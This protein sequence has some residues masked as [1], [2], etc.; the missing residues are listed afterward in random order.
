MGN[1]DKRTVLGGGAYMVSSNST[2][3]RADLVYCNSLRALYNAYED[4][5]PYN[6]TVISSSPAILRSNLKNVH[7]VTPRQSAAFIPE[8][9]RSLAHDIFQ[10]AKSHVFSHDIA[11]FAARHLIEFAGHVVDASALNAEH[12]ITPSAS[13]LGVTGDANIDYRINGPWFELLRP[14]G[15]CTIASYDIQFEHPAFHLQTPKVGFFSAYNKFGA[16]YALK[17][18]MDWAWKTIPGLF[19]KGNIKIIGD[20]PLLQEVT[21]HLGTSGYHVATLPPMAYWDDSGN[22]A[23]RQSMTG[24]AEVIAPMLAKAF[25]NFVIPEIVTSLTAL[26]FKTLE[27][28]VADFYTGLEHWPDALEIRETDAPPIDAVLFSGALTGAHKALETVCDDYHIPLIGL[29]STIGPESDHGTAHRSCFLDRAVTPNVLCL[30]QASATLNRS[31]AFISR[32]SKVTACGLPGALQRLETA[33]ARKKSL[34]YVSPVQFRQR[35]KGYPF[36]TA[37]NDL[38]QAEIDILK[39]V[40]VPSDTPISYVPCW[41]MGLPDF[42]PAIELVHEL[43]QFTLAA[44]YDEYGHALKGYSLLVTAGAGAH[45]ALLALT[46]QPLVYV[47]DTALPIPEGEFWD[48]LKDAAFICSI[49]TPDDVADTIALLKKSPAEIYALWQK[50]SK[51]RRVLRAYLGGLSQGTA[52]VTALTYIQ[53]RMKAAQIQKAKAEAKKDPEN[54]EAPDSDFTTETTNTDTDENHI[55][56][57]NDDITPHNQ[58]HTA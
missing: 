48:L 54:P 13:V 6:A 14:H 38:A 49:K 55:D 10:V 44:P 57:T 51:A 8:Q 20:S 11:P 42:C 23:A 31:T 34:A 39:H 24:L 45:L 40:L 12:L 33:P 19:R 21:H 1:F 50:R 53:D 47:T 52:G 30:T 16:E 4:G 35:E 26:Y 27:K 37:D 28:D 18:L 2:L 15:Y 46:D 5:L 17:P 56:D 25:T 7:P 58:R 36:M 9:L 32:D 29:Q 43:T 22:R 41:E 3:E